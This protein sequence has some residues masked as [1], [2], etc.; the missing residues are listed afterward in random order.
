MDKQT[1]QTLA[2]L[3]IAKQHREA[4]E[5]TINKMRPLIDAMVQEYKDDLLTV[6]YDFSEPGKT[7][8]DQE[9]GLS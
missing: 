4:T 1:Q 3:A 8:T 9:R 2:N 5:R 7:A 6:T